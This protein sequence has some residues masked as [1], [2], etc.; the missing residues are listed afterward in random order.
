MVISNE[1]IEKIKNFAKDVKDKEIYNLKGELSTKDKN[2]RKKNDT[3][4]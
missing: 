2:N 4:F 1:D 3:R